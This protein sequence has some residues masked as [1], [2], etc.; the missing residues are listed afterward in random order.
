MHITCAQ[1]TLL[2][3]ACMLTEKGAI[4]VYIL[5]SQSVIIA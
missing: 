5:S 4:H 3:Y 2:N 1:L